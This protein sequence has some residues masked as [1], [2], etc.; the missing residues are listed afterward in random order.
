[1]RP[2]GTEQ[3]ERQRKKLRSPLHKD[4][5][6]LTERRKG[7][8]RK[9]REERQRKGKESQQDNQTVDAPSSPKEIEKERKKKKGH[10]EKRQ[11]G[12]RGGGDGTT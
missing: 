6:L 10:R 2:I 11:I 12:I 9:E 3:K 5:P 7:E 1:M 8:G 4:A